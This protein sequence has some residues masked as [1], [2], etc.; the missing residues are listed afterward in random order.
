VFDEL[1]FATCIEP[2]SA[3]PDAPNV[4]PHVLEPGESLTAWYRIEPVDRR[5]GQPGA[6]PQAAPHGSGIHPR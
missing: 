4:R 3:P 6:G 5:D 2:Q 1:P